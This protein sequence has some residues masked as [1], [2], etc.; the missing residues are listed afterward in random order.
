MGWMK[1]CGDGV[2][3]QREGNGYMRK[4]WMVWFTGWGLVGCLLAF[5]LNPLY[6]WAGSSAKKQRWQVVQRL[7]LSIGPYLWE[8]HGAFGLVGHVN[9]GRVTLVDTRTWK[10]LGVRSWGKGQVYVSVRGRWGLVALTSQQQLLLVSLPSMK[11]HRRYKVP[12]YPYGVSLEGEMQPTSTSTTQSARRPAWPRHALIADQ[13]GGRLLRWNLEQ[14]RVVRSQSMTW[15]LHVRWGVS[16]IVV[17]PLTGS[18]LWL[19]PTSWKILHTWKSKEVVGDI[20]VHRDAVAVVYGD[21]KKKDGKLTFFQEHEKRLQWQAS[22]KPRPRGVSLTEN[23][24]LVLTE[25][26]Q[27]QVFERSNGKL[28]QQMALGNN[29]LL[30]RCTTSRECIALLPLSQEL[31]RLS[32]R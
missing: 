28:Y 16:G 26:G 15:P 18:P 20:S 25:S 17:I 13:I 10:I 30:L 32:L 8:S 23:H 9:E 27:L 4:T 14:G 1:L 29:G 6:G 31:I 7:P 3:M 2:W 24:V 12:F 21:E 11:V 5:S 22:T 19:H